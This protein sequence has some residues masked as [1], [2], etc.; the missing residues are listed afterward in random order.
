MSMRIV[1][2]GPVDGDPVLG[3]GGRKFQDESRSWKM[4]TEGRMIRT[5]SIAMSRCNTVGR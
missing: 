3:I 5:S 1:R 2:P 4:L